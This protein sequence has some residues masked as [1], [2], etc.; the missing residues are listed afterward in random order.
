MIYDTNWQALGVGDFYINYFKDIPAIGYLKSLT[1]GYDYY[2]VDS[3]L[4]CR[5]AIIRAGYFSNLKN[6]D[7]KGGEWRC[8]ALYYSQKGNDIEK[9]LAIKKLWNLHPFAYLVMITGCDDGHLAFYFRTEE[10]AKYILQ[11]CNSI[12][13]LCSI[14][15]GC[16][17][18][19]SDSTNVVCVMDVRN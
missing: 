13:D 7:N 11:M 4:G 6:S 5:V 10:E 15:T 9:G 2:L 3:N 19:A 12:E 1:A 18:L 8:D 16:N 14:S 17:Q